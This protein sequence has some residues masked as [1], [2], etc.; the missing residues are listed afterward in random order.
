MSTPQNDVSVFITSTHRLMFPH[1]DAPHQFLDENGKPDGAPEYSVI[2]LMPYNHPDVPAMMAAMQAVHTAEA[3]SKFKGMPFDMLD[4]V[5]GI[6]NPIM[7]GD[8]YADKMIARGGDP[9]NYEA[10]RGHYYLKAKSNAERQPAVFKQ[11]EGQPEGPGRHEV[12]DIKTEMYGGCYG[13][14]VLK[15]IG[16]ENKGK[17]GFTFYINSILKTAEGPRLGGSGSASANDYDFGQDATDRA[18]LLPGTAAVPALP[19]G[20]GAPQMA[21]PG[22]VM[23]PGTAPTPPMPGAAAPVY[24]PPVPAAQRPPLPSMTPP[25]VPGAQAVPPAYTPP[26]PVYQAPPQMAPP[27]PVAA[28]PAP[29][30]AEWEG[31]ATV[32]FDNGT[33]WEYVQ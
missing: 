5:D 27:T 4:K 14:G 20:T 11:V 12:I 23:T 13:R 16:W 2:F 25:P 17:Y 33:N 9:A 7:V 30:Y 21:A 28:A 26:A 1:L 19:Q 24:T 29:I 15:V 8:H 6:R 31:R 22:R 3:L 32:S 10:Y 18:V